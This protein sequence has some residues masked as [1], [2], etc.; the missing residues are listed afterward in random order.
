MRVSTIFPSSSP[1]IIS[2]NWKDKTRRDKTRQERMTTQEIRKA[3]PSKNWSQSF[4]SIQLEWDYSKRRKKTFSLWRKNGTASGCVFVSVQTSDHRSRKWKRWGSLLFL[5][6]FLFFNLEKKIFLF[7]LFDFFL[8]SHIIKEM[9]QN[10]IDAHWGSIMQ[11]CVW[12]N[13]YYMLISCWN[14]WLKL[15]NLV[16]NTISQR[17]SWLSLS[18]SRKSTK[19]EGK[20]NRRFYINCDRL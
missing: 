9:Y 13:V 12:C 14:C 6:L 15:F 17:Y 2:R 10:S 11:R 16:L 8:S 20:V 4:L 1:F 19:M 7:I 3:I 5:L 18:I